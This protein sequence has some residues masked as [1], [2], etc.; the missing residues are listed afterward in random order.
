MKSLLPS[1]YFFRSLS[2]SLCLSACLSVSLPPLGHSVD[3]D[4]LF[5]DRLHVLRRSKFTQSDNSG[6]IFLL[7]RR[8]L[9]T[10]HIYV[11]AK[12]LKNNTNMLKKAVMTTTAFLLHLC[13]SYREIMR[14]IR[15]S[16]LAVSSWFSRGLF[17]SSFHSGSSGSASLS[18]RQSVGTMLRTIDLRR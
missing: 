10:S 12:V 15:H 4:R 2:L 3:R 9:K 1:F 17:L 18:A 7:F 5:K 8:F 16:C 11:S 6:Y 14:K 13:R